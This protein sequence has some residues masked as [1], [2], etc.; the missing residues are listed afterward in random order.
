M[1]REYFQ[2]YFE[3]SQSH[4]MGH[5]GGALARGNVATSPVALR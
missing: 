3:P 2:K 4:I 5:A 1:W